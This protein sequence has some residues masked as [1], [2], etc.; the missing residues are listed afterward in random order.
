MM[1]VQKSQKQKQLHVGMKPSNKMGMTPQ[2]DI[3]SLH[4]CAILPTT[5]CVSCVHNWVV[6]ASGYG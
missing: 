1:Y 6:E 5:P 4:L 2:Y 3:P